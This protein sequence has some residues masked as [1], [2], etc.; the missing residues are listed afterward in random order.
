M[1][2]QLSKGRRRILFLLDDDEWTSGDLA[3]VTRRH[4]TNVSRDLRFM[5]KAGLVERRRDALKVYYRVAKT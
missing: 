2:R 5:L 3:A 1:T 4:Q